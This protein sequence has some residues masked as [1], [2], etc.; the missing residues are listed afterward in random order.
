MA[1]SVP[2]SWSG[3]EM[4][5][6]SSRLHRDEDG[7]PLVIIVATLREW[8]DYCS[9]LPEQIKHRQHNPIRSA[10]DPLTRF[11]AECTVRCTDH[12]R[13]QS[14]HLHQAFCSWARA[15]GESELTATAL[16]RE[17]KKRRFNSLHSSIN[18][19]L[20]MRL[21]RRASTCRPRSCV[22]RSHPSKI[23]SV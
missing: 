17:L 1:L 19:W 7:P 5:K 6:P 22:K 3:A 4:I 14:S 23:G 2:S 18:Y 15:N 11:L 13:I 9:Q 10:S 21:T 8:L 12:E 16:G 20:G